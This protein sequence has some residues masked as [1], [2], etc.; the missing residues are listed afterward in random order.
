MEEIRIIFKSNS[1][2]Q[3]SMTIPQLDENSIREITV[4]LNKIIVSD[5][6]VLFLQI[7][8]YNDA[9]QTCYYNRKTG[10]S[11]SSQP[12]NVNPELHMVYI[13]KFIKVCNLYVNDC[14]IMRKII[15]KILYTRQ[16]TTLNN[17]LTGLNITN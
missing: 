6:A 9:S 17:S 11:S 10:F 7:D 15:D 8:A 16:Q 1:E 5:E 4:W 14:K 13:N 3:I 2:I 12:Y